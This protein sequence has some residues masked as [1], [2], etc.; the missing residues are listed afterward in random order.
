MKITTCTINVGKGIV[1]RLLIIDVFSFVDVFFILERP[2][3]RDGRNIVHEHG[4]F[5][6]FSFECEGGVE[7][8]VRTSIVGLFSLETHNK[9]SVDL[10]YV[11]RD[12]VSRCI[13]GVYI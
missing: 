5:D 11:G 13:G 7:V 12:D 10:S 4:D 1:N 9:C 3:K 2:V 8:F 6:L